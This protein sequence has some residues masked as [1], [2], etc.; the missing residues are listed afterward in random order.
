MST[1]DLPASQAPAGRRTEGRCGLV[2]HAAFLAHDTGAAHPER[3]ARLQAVLEG[4]EAGGLRAEL[5]E[6]VAPLAQRAWVHA[7]HPPAHV[8]AL[9]SACARPRSVL[10][11]GDTVAGPGSFEAALR[12]SGGLV[13]ACARVL[14][15][16]WRQ[17]FVAARPPG[18]HAGAA[19]VM[20]FC[21]LNHVAVAARWLRA[22]GRL[23]R[24]A[25]VDWDVHHGNGTQHI[26]ERDGSVYYAS[27]HQYPFYPGTGAA[28]ERGSGPGE[29]TTLNVPLPAGTEDSRWLRGFEERVLPAL[30][31]FR[32][33]FVLVS[34]GFDAHADDPLGGMALSARAYG[35]MTRRL[36]ELARRHAGGRLVS[37]LEGGYDLAALAACA[38]AH[39]EE[40][41][42]AP[43][44]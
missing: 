33:Q 5:E 22:Q 42:A 27:M 20:G 36:S 34:A 26:F 17:A 10:D 44:E 30:E 38:R 16:R 37:F 8:Q 14:D 13:E 31:D 11:A 19:E 18:H 24:V 43:A 25:I 40:L 1:P 35:E 29:G 3:P 12:A 4:L 6:L 23:E 32:P 7:V 39:V 15:G 41:L 2:T 9:E 21:L 28:S